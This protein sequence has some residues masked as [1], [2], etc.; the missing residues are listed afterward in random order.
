VVRFFNESYGEGSGVSQ[1]INYYGFCEKPV[2]EIARRKPPWQKSSIYNWI[3]ENRLP[4]LEKAIKV[5][6]RDK[7]STSKNPMRRNS[8]LRGKKKKFRI[9]Q[10]KG[11]LS[12]A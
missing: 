12:H 8:G 7:N 5:L 1:Y 3:I 4:R 10:A 9:H 11:K 2:L 6:T